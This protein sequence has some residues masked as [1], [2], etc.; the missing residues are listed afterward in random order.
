MGALTTV[1]DG[2]VCIIVAWNWRDIIHM[3]Q[4]RFVKLFLHLE[5]GRGGG[6][7]TKGM[8]TGCMIEDTKFEFCRSGRLAVGVVNPLSDLIFE[9][10]DNGRESVICWAAGAAPVAAAV[11]KGTAAKETGVVDAMGFPLQSSSAESSE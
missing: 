11:L 7:L 6:F 3:G 8:V 1:N 5:V 4:I 9:M 10:N 2:D